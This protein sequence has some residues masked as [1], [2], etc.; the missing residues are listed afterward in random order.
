MRG[1][2]GI[3]RLHAVAARPDER[4]SSRRRC[5]RSTT[6][7]S[8]TSRSR[9]RSTTARTS[10]RRSPATST[11]KRAHSLGAVNSINWARIAGAGRLLLQGLLRGHVRPN[12]EHGELRRAVRQLRQHARRPRRAADGPAD[13][14]L[15]RRDERERRARR[16]LPHRP[17]PAARRRRDARDVVA[18]DGHLA[19]RRTSSASCSTWSGATPRACASCGSASSTIASSTSPARRCGRACARI[20]LRLRTQHA[21]RPAGDDP[22]RAPPLRH[23]HRSAHGRRRQGRTRASRRRTCRSSASRP[24]CPA[25]FAAT[26]RE[27][28]GVEPPRPAAFA[29][30]ESRPQR[31]TLLPADA[32]RVKA[33]VAAHAATHG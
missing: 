20:R 10:S 33:F 5:T 26:I 19:R 3:A 23:R 32:A 18:V 24:R 2:R 8:T 14:R 27:A 6:R 13:R 11:F 15:D 31:C 22:R 1:K 9:A 21:R 25:K 7:T 17:L 30:L 12:D 16:V 29:D 4:R 28:L